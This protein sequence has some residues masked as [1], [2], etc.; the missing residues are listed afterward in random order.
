LYYANNNGIKLIVNFEH[1]FNNIKTK[2][3]K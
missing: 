3:N 1:F 2:I